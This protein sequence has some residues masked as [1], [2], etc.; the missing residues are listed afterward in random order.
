MS[1]LPKAGM[2]LDP[3][4][5][6]AYIDKRL[7]PEQRAA[8]EAELAMDPDGYAVL[9]ESIK[10]LDGMPSAETVSVNRPG[11]RRWTAIAASLAAAAAIAALVV[12][13]GAL[14]RFTGARSNPQLE[15]VLAAAGEGRYVEA[16]VTGGF[17]YGPLRSMTRGEAESARGTALRTVVNSLMAE[18]DRDSSINTRH[19]LGVAQ[20]QAG[21]A[22]AAA[23]TLGEIPEPLRSASVRSDLAAA[24]IA[25]ARLTDTTA[26]LS[27]AAT[28][29]ARAVDA[30]PRLPEARFNRALALH[31]SG[32]P[33][34]RQAWE[35]YLQLDSTSPWAAEARQYLTR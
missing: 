6:A 11:R 21:D 7:S 24:L 26:D 17:S 28:E 12:Q 30:D 9:V 29:A 3:E 19:A 13:S 23:A 10:T 2:N 27:L 34:A 15:R 35:D 25:R 16:R 14:S 20:L 8:V 22:E 31:L 1:N 18:L 4:M 32:S 5:L 33:G